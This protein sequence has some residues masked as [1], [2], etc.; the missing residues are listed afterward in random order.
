[1]LINL[2]QPLLYFCL[3][4]HLLHSQLKQQYGCTCHQQ[5]RYYCR[6]RYWWCCAHRHIWYHMLQETTK[7]VELRSPLRQRSLI[8]PHMPRLQHHHHPEPQPATSLRNSLRHPI[9]HPSLQPTCLYPAHVQPTVPATASLYPTPS[10]DH[11]SNLI[12]M[13]QIIF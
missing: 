11:H 5:C 1:M 3:I 4:V 9:S 2:L 8:E 7:C 12:F 6:C 10:P 13:Y